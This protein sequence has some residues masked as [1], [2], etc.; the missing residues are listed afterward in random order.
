MIAQT[1]GKKTTNS[2]TGYEKNIWAYP[3]CT[4]CSKILNAE[5][6]KKWAVFTGVDGDVIIP[7]LIISTLMGTPTADRFEWDRREMD[8]AVFPGKSKSARFRLAYKMGDRNDHT[9]LGS[10][11]LNFYMLDTA[12]FGWTFGSD[13]SE[14]KFEGNTANPLHSVCEVVKSL[15]CKNGEDFFRLFV[16]SVL[17]ASLRALNKNWG[18][19]G[20]G[21]SSVVANTAQKYF[22]FNEA[23]SSRGQRN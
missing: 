4:G 12:Y 21:Q 18:V 5:L 6:T 23:I 16:D 15:L 20:A 8:L 2:K 1:T 14:S 11:R 7:N 22:Y 13:M 19:L 10:L 9:E 3:F 17:L